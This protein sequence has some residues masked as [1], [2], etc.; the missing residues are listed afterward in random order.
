MQYIGP[1]CAGNK[2]KIIQTE[3]KEENG[4]KKKG[5]KK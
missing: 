1:T 2:N 3:M 5:N 4:D